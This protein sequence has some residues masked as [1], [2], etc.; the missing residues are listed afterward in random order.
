MWTAEARC[1]P[2]CIRKKAP[3]NAAR[4]GKSS[5]VDEAVNGEHAS[6]TATHAPARSLP[7]PKFCPQPPA[8]IPRARCEN[9]PMAHVLTITELAPALPDDWSPPAA[10]G[11]LSSAHFLSPRDR[12]S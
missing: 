3:K 1:S 4:R 12:A 8:R 6:G 9:S 5:V 10:S 7:S 2:Y 11:S